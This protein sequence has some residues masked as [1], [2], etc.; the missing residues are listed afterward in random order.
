MSLTVSVVG[1]GIG[2]LCT[3]WALTRL[4]HRV[5]VFDRGPIPNP[6]SASF[7]QHRLTRTFYPGQPWYSR[8]V[9]DS[10]AAWD[11]LWDD[12]GRS[13]YV[14]CGSLALKR[15]GSDWANR[16]VAALDAVGQEYRIIDRDALARRFPFLVL[17][18]VEWGLE[19]R[20]GGVLLADR[21]LDGL[22]RHLAARGV[23]LRPDTPVAAIDP[24]RASV[25]LAGGVVVEADSL[26]VAAGPWVGRLLPDMTSRFD[27]RR[28]TVVYVRPPDA[29]AE[30]WTQAP[31]LIDWGSDGG[32]W[33]IP[34]V[35]GTGLKLAAAAH[36]RP[37]DPDAERVASAEDIRAIMSRYRG[38]LRDP[39]EY[40]VTEGRICYYVMA[41]EER[42]VIEPLGRSW[43]LSAC[44]GHGFKSGAIV[45]LKAADAVA[46]RAAPADVT[47]WAAGLSPDPQEVSSP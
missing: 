23:T 41:P 3:A 29:Y 22:A 42:Y 5:T 44:S 14:E 2:G 27:P 21:I 31:G 39:D 24:D 26:V 43:L 17:D 37:G 34:P 1:A 36:T 33:S 16:A 11:L 28:V 47:R 35:A 30:A 13:H 18:D 32:Q 46:G 38:L 12:L 4:G 10:F 9:L 15:P 8:L 6:L 40:H 20:R 25:T 45:G 7:D 19:A